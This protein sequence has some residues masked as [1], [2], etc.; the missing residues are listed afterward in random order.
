MR[1]SSLFVLGLLLAGCGKPVK[2]RIALVGVTVI[3][4]TDAPAREDQVMIIRGSRIDTIA[5]AAGFAIP[6]TATVIDLKGKWVIPGLIDADGRVDRWAVKRYLAFGVTAVRDVGN[7][8]DSILALAEGAALHS[9]VSPRLYVTGAALDGATPFDSSSA[10]LSAESDARRAVDDRVQAGVSFVS[11]GPGFTPA[12]LRAVMDE[13][14]SL[15]T[16]VT[17]RL[18]LTDARA[19]A[20]MGIRSLLELSGVPQAVVNPD[21]FY[22]AYR[23]SPWAG[24]TTTERAWAGLDSA[25]LGA[26]AT[27][28]ATAGVTLVPALVLHDTWS[29]LDDTAVTASP[30][31]AYV[32]ATARADW[33]ISRFE[34]RAGWNASTYPAFRAGRSKEDLFV[35]EF[36]LAGGRIAAGSGAARMML[37]PGAS[38]QREL[39]LLVNAGLPTDDAIRSATSVAAALIGADS[40]GTL[41]P[42][43]VAD[44]LVLSAD[45]LA[46]I[47]NT[48]SIVK[49]VLGGAVLDADSLV[50]RIRQ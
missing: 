27:D 15:N 30:D 31:L 44:L 47:R 3:D 11:T 42:G 4:G 41:E 43:K 14:T 34:A 16:S 20:K 7:E 17:A 18:G 37:V 48:R 2:D 38:L 19:A 13:A 6:K 22:A 32:P 28:L 50:R 23:K 49:V 36:K 1:K 8:Q 12:L 26:V 45:P 24:W 35:R 33:D 39:E 5:P 40:L 21:P 46:D 29:R 25:P 10:A 9:L